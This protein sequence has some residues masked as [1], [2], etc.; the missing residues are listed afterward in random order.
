MCRQPRRLHWRVP[1]APSTG[2]VG[3]LFTAVKGLS[4]PPS[5]ARSP[6]PVRL[7]P[8][9]MKGCNAPSAGFLHENPEAELLVR[10][11]RLSITTDDSTELIGHVSERHIWPDKSDR[12]IH[13]LESGVPISAPKE[14]GEPVLDLRRSRV[15]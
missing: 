2:G 6:R 9:V 11:Q 13:R 5:V 15:P 7:Q 1:R 3:R 14:A 4:C 10:R 12:H 8:R